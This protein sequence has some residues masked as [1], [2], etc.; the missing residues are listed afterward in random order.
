MPVTCM[1]SRGKNAIA[2]RARVNGVL[3][4]VAHLPLDRMEKIS[5]RVTVMASLVTYQAGMHSP[6]RHG[7]R[8]PGTGRRA[9]AHLNFSHDP[10]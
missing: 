7:R 1:S 10:W 5:A 9:V 4:E 6:G 8:R 3:T 2:V